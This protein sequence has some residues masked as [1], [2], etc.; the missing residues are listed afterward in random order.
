MFFMEKRKENKLIII[1]GLLFILIGS[2]TLIY[3]F[4]DDFIVKHNNKKAIETYYEEETIEENNNEVI[5]QVEIEPDHDV[6]MYHYVSIL[7][8]PKIGLENGIVGKNN[9]YNKVYYGIEMLE[10]SD[11]PDV[12]NGDFILAAHNGSSPVSHFR[13]LYK[14]NINDEAYVDYKGI[15]YRYKLV[16]KYDIEKN[17]KALIKTTNQKNNLVLI[18]CKGNTKYQT[19]YIFEL[20]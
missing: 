9:I 18:T 1:I 19:V 17:G 11:Y 8:I 15:T 5:E 3:G 14:L 6:R 4:K 12:E 13:N 16:D 10:E 2:G 20:I 7:K